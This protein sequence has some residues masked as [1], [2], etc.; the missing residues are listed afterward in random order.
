MLMEYKKGEKYM[1]IHMHTHIYACVC[2]CIYC[3][4]F[5][6]LFIS[7]LFSAFR[8]FLF[9]VLFFLSLVTNSSPPPDVTPNGSLRRRRSRVPS[10]EDDH[11][12]MDY[13][14]TSGHDGSRERKSW[15]GMGM[16]F[17]L[18]FRV[19]RFL[20]FFSRYVYEF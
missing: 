20:C 11:K 6:I 17:P 8:H 14:H 9:S 4:H 10:E 15:T 12:L 16:S 3:I 18:I 13:L 7:R 19:F 1:Y 2:V 5:S